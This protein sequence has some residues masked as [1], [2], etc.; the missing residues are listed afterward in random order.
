MFWRSVES[1]MGQGWAPSVHRAVN[2]AVHRFGNLNI[3]Q[4]ERNAERR[5]YL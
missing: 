3:F 5:G 4:V 2:D 1:H